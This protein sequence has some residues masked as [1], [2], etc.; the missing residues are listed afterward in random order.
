MDTTIVEYLQKKMIQ[1]AEERGSLMHPDV[2]EISQQLDRFIVMAQRIN[3]TMHAEAQR[4][5]TPIAQALETRAKH[6]V[7]FATS[8]VNHF[9]RDTIEYAKHPSKREKFVTKQ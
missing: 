2:I 3:L 4:D 8:Y 6:L 7:R 5:S 9:A 1:A